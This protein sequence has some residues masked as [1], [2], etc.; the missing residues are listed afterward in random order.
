METLLRDLRFGMKLLW[1]E[2]AFSATVLLTLAVC[3]GANSTIFSVINTILLEPL[4]YAGA[5]RL[6]TLYNSY[7]GAGAERASN[8]GPDFFFRRDQIDAFE[9][10]ANYQG[11]ANTVGETG[12]TERARSMRVTSTFLPL[13]RVTPVLGR[14]F[15]WEEMEPGSHQKVILGYEYW[16]NRY[17]GAEAVL[18]TDLRVDGEPFTIVGVLPESFRIAGQG[19]PRDFLL[20][21]PFRPEERTLEGWHN[22]NYEQM[23]RLAPE[24]SIELAR[25]QLDAMNNRLV[26]EWPVPEARQL[27]TDAGFHSQIHPAKE[28]MLREIR[29]SL[30]MLWAGVAFV[31]LL[32]CV[33][34]ANLMLARSNVR[35]R[36]L[37]TRLAL[38]ADRARLG[39]QLLTEA[40]LLGAIGGMIKFGV[41]GLFLGAVIL[42]LGYQIISEWIW[43]NKS[44]PETADDA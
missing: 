26:E 11:W 42:G 25:A 32:G 39:R 33:N 12:S 14:N 1:K 3:I 35:M 23:A 21:I 10:V 24:V 44:G 40:L 22:N 29:P 36:E 38:G 19:E 20:P 13:L 17:E 31:L 28:E 8:G 16:Q 18:G 41:I 27:L 7:P 9:E 15:L 37:A 43:P 30:L 34:I 6:V 4:P 5:D 2:R